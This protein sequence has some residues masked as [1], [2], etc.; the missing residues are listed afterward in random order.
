MT[1]PL[2][3]VLYTCIC[4]DDSPYDILV[5]IDEDKT[6]KEMSE[7]IDKLVIEPLQKIIDGI[8]GDTYTA[9]NIQA[10]INKLKQ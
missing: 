8:E 10:L 1:N 9:D 6:K 3:E 5:D 4:F 2:T 7:V